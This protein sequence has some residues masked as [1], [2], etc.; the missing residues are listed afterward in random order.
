MAT[1]QSN[2]NVSLKGPEDWEAWNTQ[3]ESKAISTDLQRLI[4]PNE[5]QEDIEPF[6]EKPTPPKI[7]DYDKKLTRETRSQS[8]QSSA[9]AQGTQPI[10]QTEEVDHASRP[11]TA[12][13]MTT[14]ARQAFQ[15]DWT[16]YQ[17]DFKIY[18]TERE[19]ID[20]LRNWVLKI[21]SEHLIRTSCD[22]KDTIKGW[23]GK[24]K[25]QVGVSDTK[26]KRDARSLYKVANKPLTKAL[27][28]PLAQLNTWEE[29]ITLA[30]E[31]KVLEAQSLDVWFEDFSLAIRGF[32][33]EWIMS[34]EM[35]H[36]TD[37]EDGTLTFRKL[38]NDL[39]K[40]LLKGYTTQMPK[41]GRVMA[42]GAFGPS[43][44]DLDDTKQLKEDEQEKTKGKGKGKRK[45]T[46][47]ES[48]AKCPTYRFQGHI[49]PNCLYM[50][51]E[52]AKGTFHRRKDWQ[53][54]VNKKLEE[55]DQL[56]KEV[57]RIKGKKQKEGE[58]NRD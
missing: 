21:T 7:G 25:E 54:E 48:L 23:Y 33:K 44:A 13:Q 8:S 15:L 12:A 58:A 56:R 47:G 42:K 27:R 51:L 50:F 30:K 6:A 40:E 1:T 24:L 43:F 53:E 20:K 49:L 57:D 4:S 41:A 37:I 3:F 18:T 29:A 31:K 9:M 36:A 2:E 55:D 34:Y 35:L 39:R 17:H 32:M 45:M 14:A 52:K 26:L 22:P 28:D 11:R 19:A 46:I 38:A 10:V 5:D 16:L